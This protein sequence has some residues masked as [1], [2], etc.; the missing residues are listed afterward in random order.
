MS[1]WMGK[2]MNYSPLATILAGT[3]SSQL[4]GPGVRL[5]PPCALT[6]LPGKG[7]PIPLAWGG[8]VS[9]KMQTFL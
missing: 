1:E 2:E 6:H 5:M 3:H 4:Q 7:E 9:L 8:F